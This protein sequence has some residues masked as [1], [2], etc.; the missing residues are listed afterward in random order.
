MA[1]KPK[2][3]KSKS[4][5]RPKK[6]DPQPEKLSPECRRW[7]EEI[8]E[9]LDRRIETSSGREVRYLETCMLAVGVCEQIGIELS[10]RID[11]SVVPKS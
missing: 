1:T 9:Y 6:S 7:Y 3:K 11:R 2:T 8:Q 10:D 5:H 4:A